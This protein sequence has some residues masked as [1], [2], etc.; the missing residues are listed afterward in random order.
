LLQ[1]LQQLLCLMHVGL[2]LG[3]YIVLWSL[4]VRLVYLLPW[5]AL[6]NLV[7]LLLPCCPAAQS[8]EKRKVKLQV[9]INLHGLA[10]V[11][12]AT[13]YEEEECEEAVPVTASGTPAQ[14]AAAAAANGPTANGAAAGGEAPM[15]AEPAAAAAAA[16]EA[17]AAEQPAAAAEQPA[18]GEQWAGGVASVFVR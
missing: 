3:S 13:L 18:A 12:S 17:A 11:D 4:T 9:S 16:D 14:A 8:A 2:L 10:A 1:Q 5:N 7:I 6:L 15:E